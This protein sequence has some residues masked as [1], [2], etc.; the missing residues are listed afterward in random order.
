MT[1]SGILALA[2][3]DQIDQYCNLV[4]QHSAG[5]ESAGNDMA[6]NYYLNP[7]KSLLQ[8]YS[9]LMLTEYMNDLLVEIDEITDLELNG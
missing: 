5:C 6:D 2:M 4:S 7:I 3:Q 8:K 9:N 1:D